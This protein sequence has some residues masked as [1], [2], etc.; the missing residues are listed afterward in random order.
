M[1]GSDSANKPWVMQKLQTIQPKTI[2]D[3]GAGN[4]KFGQRVKSTFGD[5][6][7]IDAI[8]AWEPYINQFNLRSIYNNVFNEDA[9]LWKNF[10]Y[11]LVVFGDVL[12]HMSEAEAVKLWNEASSAAKYGIITIPI[13]HYPQGAEFGNP[14]E[15]HHEEDWNTRRILEAFSGITDHKE[16]SITGAYFAEFNK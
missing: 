10:S 7:V 12:E 13:I 1:P 15:I 6:V 4:G 3:V 11:D 16:F 14:F 9:R 8:E 5:S 2:L